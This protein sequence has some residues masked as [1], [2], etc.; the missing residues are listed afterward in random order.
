MPRCIGA[1]STYIAGQHGILMWAYHEPATLRIELHQIIDIVNI[2]SGL[3]LSDA[4]NALYGTFIDAEP[5]YTKTDF[6]PIVID[7]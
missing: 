7:K 6:S 2:T 3:P 1:E 5:K 4:T